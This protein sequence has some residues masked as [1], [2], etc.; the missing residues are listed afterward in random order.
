MRPDTDDKACKCVFCYI[1]KTEITVEESDGK[2]SYKVSKKEAIE[3]Y[4]IYIAKLKD[5]EKVSKVL[6]GNPMSKFQI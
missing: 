5:D 1:G 6:T 4:R 3:D 2:P